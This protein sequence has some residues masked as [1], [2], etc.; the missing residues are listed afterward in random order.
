MTTGGVICFFRVPRTVPT[1][2]VLD[3]VHDSGQ[4]YICRGQPLVPENK[5]LN[6]IGLNQIEHVVLLLNCALWSTFHSIVDT[7]FTQLY[8]ISEIIICVGFGSIETCCIEID[9]S[10]VTSAT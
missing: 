5:R 3:H 1:L 8:R 4:C 6:T 9:C 2:E 7:N 10:I